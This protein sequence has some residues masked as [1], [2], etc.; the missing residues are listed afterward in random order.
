EELFVLEGDVT[1]KAGTMTRGSYFWRPE[2]VTHGPYRS[3]AGLLCFLRGH[4]E[5][6]AH[7]IENEHATV[8]DNRAYAARLGREAEASLERG[9]GL[10]P[11]S[12]WRSSPRRT[13]PWATCLQRAGR[14]ASAARCSRE[15]LT[16]VA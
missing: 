7:W 2:Y 9:W 5:L 11:V 15:I 10:W 14:S 4:G 16:R 8:A 1:G 6:H 13:F 12:M 3:E